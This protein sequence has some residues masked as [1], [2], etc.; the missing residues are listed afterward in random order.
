M[1]TQIANNFSLVPLLEV[2][3]IYRNIKI[4]NTKNILILPFSKYIESNVLKRNTC[5]QTKSIYG[6]MLD[7]CL[8]QSKLFIILFLLDLSAATC[9]TIVLFSSLHSQLTRAV[10]RYV[11]CYIYRTFRYCSKY[12]CIFSKVTVM[13][14]LQHILR[15]VY[16][17]VFLNYEFLFL[18]LK[19]C[20]PRNQSEI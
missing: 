10:T 20:L 16:K 11:N 12:S 19:V 17:L 9:T 8:L 18:F 4:N 7:T 3:C 5:T 1:A 6:F 13:Q 2:I 14:N 15:N